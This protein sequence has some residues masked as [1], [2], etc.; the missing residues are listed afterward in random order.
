MTGSSP[1]GYQITTLKPALDTA[2]DWL[3]R[4]PTLGILSTLKAAL[5]R[6]LDR[7]KND[8]VSWGNPLFHYRNLGMT[9][10]NATEWDIIV[11][12]G[13]DVTHRLVCIQKLQL[14]SA[15]PLNAPGG[16]ASP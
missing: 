16:G 2:K 9:M 7:L 15:N 14:Q 10:Y 13:V 6:I 11:T 8:P 5:A 12:Y 4:A 3:R 1:G